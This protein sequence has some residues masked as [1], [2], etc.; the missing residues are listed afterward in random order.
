MALLHLEHRSAVDIYAPS[1]MD[2]YGTA[3]LIAALLIM[4]TLL[5]VV[6]APMLTL[7][8]VSEQ[9]RHAPSPISTPI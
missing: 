7:Q 2:R 9:V 6:M 3:L 4:L 1:I 8:S 5:V